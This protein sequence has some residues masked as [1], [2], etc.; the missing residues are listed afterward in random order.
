MRASPGE[1]IDLVGGAHC[2]SVRDLSGVRKA[3]G[4]L[5][6]EVGAREARALLAQLSLFERRL[7]RYAAK[8]GCFAMASV[9][10]TG[11]RGIWLEY[12]I[13][14]GRGLNL[15]LILDPFCATMGHG[16][17][18]VYLGKTPEQIWL[19]LMEQKP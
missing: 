3:V 5:A 7:R 19:R 11:E 12:S 2:R 14:D 18:A 8:R 9:Y 17:D 6:V 10:W 1:L 13:Q 16:A 15:W 4:H